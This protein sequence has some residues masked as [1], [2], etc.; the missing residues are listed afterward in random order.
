VNGL[1]VIGS[2]TYG[3]LMDVPIFDL[4]LNSPG[5]GPSAPNGP[6][7]W[8]NPSAD[9]SVDLQDVTHRL[10]IS[11]LYDLPFGPGKKF[12]SGKSAIDRLLGGFQFNVIMTGE[13]GRPLLFSGASNQGVATR[14]N[15]LPGVSVKLA[16]PTIAKWFNT[17]AFVN[18]P[19]YSFGN[20]P[21]A[22]SHARGPSQTNFDMSIF[23]TTPIRNDARLEFRIEAYN[24]LNH[25]E[26]GQ[27]NTTFVAGAPANPSNPSAEG[28]SNTSSTFGTITSALSA[29]IVQL[30]AKIIF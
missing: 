14:P 5:A 18:P 1:Q 11:G 21:R 3:K 7:N 29:R 17:A 22:Y 9:Y 10:T 15:I 4:L 27:P 28:G 12:L 23:K 16:H 25:T 26:L 6:Q 13:S 24:A 8:R 19:D 20:A 2:Y 30:G